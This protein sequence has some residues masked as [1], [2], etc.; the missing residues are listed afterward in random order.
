MQSKDPI[1]QAVIDT[2]TSG[3]RSV[4]ASNFPSE[5]EV[6]ICSLELMGTNEIIGDYTIKYFS[7]PV[8]PKQMSQ[9]E[10]QINNIKK[11][12]GGL[13][14]L[15]SNTFVPK[16][17]QIQGDFGR[18]LKI[19]FGDITETFNSID[20]GVLESLDLDKKCLTKYVKT[21]YGSIK[22]LQAIC[23][24]AKKTDNGKQRKLFFHNPALGHS[25]LVKVNSITISQSLSSNMIWQYNLSMKALCNTDD[26]EGVKT[27]LTKS[28]AIGSMQNGA[29]ALASSV[30]NAVGSGAF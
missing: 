4:L 10:P 3:T 29:N 8:M 28:L 11:T 14:S 5:F 2:I 16:D 18:S 27:G 9:V 26:I 21:G 1:I 19:L 23:E 25:Y 22:V 12:Y 7:F 6:Y 13:V 17:I 20:I 15:N 30:S 24:E